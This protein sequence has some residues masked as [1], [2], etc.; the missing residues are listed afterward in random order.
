MSNVQRYRW[1]GAP[2]PPT[3]IP[4][5]ATA[6][7]HPMHPGTAPSH[8]PSQPSQNVTPG[9]GGA[10]AIGPSPQPFDPALEQQ[11]LTAGRN[12]AIGQGEAAYQTGNLGF[13][14]GYNPDGSVNTANPYSRAA[15]FQLAHENHARGNT[16]NF[17][18]QGQLY[19]GS[20]INAQALNDSSY[21]QQDAANRLAYQRGLHGIQ[22]G[23][24]S[25]M[26]GNSLGV[27]DADFN[28]LLKATYPGS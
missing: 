28:A 14:Y 9:Q 10:P 5:N 2:K 3:G 1:G 7:G 16:N 20:L 11:K 21:A 15:L 27:G 23:Q 6:Y 22:S 18:N 4:P 17:A 13:D 8:D 25:T 24:L 26:A 19:A 12:I